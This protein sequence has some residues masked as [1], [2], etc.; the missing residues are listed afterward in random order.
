MI[1]R[2]PYIVDEKNG[3]H[4]AT[5]VERAGA[6]LLTIEEG[7]MLES[8]NKG[9]WGKWALLPLRLIIG[10]GFMAHGFAKLSRGP[11]GFAGIHSKP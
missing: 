6:L 7:E 4:T 3:R 10:Y 2:L 8:L 9:S 1:G 5:T 11:E